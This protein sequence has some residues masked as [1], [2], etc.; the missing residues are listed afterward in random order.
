MIQ[1]DEDDLI[2][3]KRLIS[4]AFDQNGTINRVDSTDVIYESFENAFMDISHPIK[5]LYGGITD[6]TVADEFK[7]KITFKRNDFDEDNPGHGTIFDVYKD[8]KR[9]VE[10]AI[11]PVIA[12]KLQYISYRSQFIQPFNINQYLVV[13]KDKKNL[14]IKK[15]LELALAYIDTYLILNPEWQ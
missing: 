7:G 11:L 6:D 15:S 8:G 9:A 13:R 4:V 5:T 2:I 12:N 1:V 3:A 10:Y 14:T